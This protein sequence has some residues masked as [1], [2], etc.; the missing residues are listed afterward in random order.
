MPEDDRNT[1]ARLRHDIDRG[2]AGD[3]VPFMDPAAAP[4]GT[5]DEAAG[6]PPTPQQIAMAREHESRIPAATTN[7]PA[8]PTTVGELAG[9]EERRGLGPII[10]LVVVVV[11][12]VLVALTL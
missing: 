1:S 11:L 8:R 9:N 12:I 5:D 2:R 6:T 3:K 7:A 10:A 4:L